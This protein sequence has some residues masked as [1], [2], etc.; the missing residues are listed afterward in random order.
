MPTAAATRQTAALGLL[1]KHRGLIMAIAIAALPIVIIRPLPTSLM[2]FL[3]TINMTL[4]VVILLTTIYVRKPLDFSVFPS[5]L[6]VATLYRLV[7]NVATTRLILSNAGERGS[8]P[9]AG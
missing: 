5:L 2:D 1:V 7:L 8:W 9:R 3:L 4:A 6:L